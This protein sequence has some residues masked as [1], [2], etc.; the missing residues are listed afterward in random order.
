MDTNAVAEHAQ[1]EVSGD[2]ARRNGGIAGLRSRKTNATE[3][4]EEAEENG[5]SS[6][7]DQSEGMDE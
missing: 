4:E 3:T 1:G 6:S 7:P 2:F 5:G